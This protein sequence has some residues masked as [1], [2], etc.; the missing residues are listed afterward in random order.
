MAIP[1]PRGS[2]KGVEGST[3]QGRERVPVLASFENST[4]RFTLEFPKPVEPGTTV[5]VVLKP[6]HNPAQADIYEF[7]VV[8]YPYGDNPQTSPAGAVNPRI[9]DRIY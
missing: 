9:Y 2:T 1:L 5:T 7:A 4:R 3:R 8:A 6:W